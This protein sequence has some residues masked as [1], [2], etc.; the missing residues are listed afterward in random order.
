MAA[1]Q[2]S[3]TPE[4]TEHNTNQQRTGIAFARKQRLDLLQPRE[5]VALA[6]GR[7]QQSEA[8]KSE[9]QRETHNETHALDV[10][11][12][13]ST[14]VFIDVAHH[15]RSRRD[16]DLVSLVAEL[17]TSTCNQWW[18]SGEKRHGLIEREHEGTRTFDR[19]NESTREQ[20]CTASEHQRA[21]ESIADG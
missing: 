17:C 21:V 3:L 1:E 4:P 13:G 19:H 20:T 2:T 5:G 8:H 15:I 14:T 10:H 12:R 11:N 18:L 9:T 7:D 6:R 16:P